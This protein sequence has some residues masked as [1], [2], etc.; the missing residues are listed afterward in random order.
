MADLG[1]QRAYLRKT[2][3]SIERECS[4]YFYAA[5]QLENH[6]QKINKLIS[7]ALAYTAKLPENNQQTE[8]GKL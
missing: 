3:K 2:L 1:H 4:G 5:E 6:R 7:S 8:K